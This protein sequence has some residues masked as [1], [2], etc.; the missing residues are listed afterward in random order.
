M[1]FLV[2]PYVSEPTR[3]LNDLKARNPELV[4]QQKQGRALLWDKPQDPELGAAFAA[5]S[6]A[7][8]PYVYASE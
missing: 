8:K 1:P 2:K 6:V 4:A 3:F 7:Q 5:A